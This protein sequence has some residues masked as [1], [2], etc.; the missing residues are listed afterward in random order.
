MSGSTISS[1]GL[2]ARRRRLLFRAWHR[3]MREVDLI[4]GPFADA[5]LAS[6]T[7]SEVDEFE[8]LMDVPEPE[9]LAWVMGQEPT[10]QAF[11]QPVFRRMR[12]FKRGAA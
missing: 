12:E 3:G 11:D 2:D 4:T 10:P 9:L 8:R 7:E 6:L 5:H 1:E